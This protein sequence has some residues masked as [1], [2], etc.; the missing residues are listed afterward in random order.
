[1]TPDLHNTRQRSDHTFPS[2]SRYRYTYNVRCM[3]VFYA[4]CFDTQLFA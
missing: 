2:T 4:L 1:M 3:A